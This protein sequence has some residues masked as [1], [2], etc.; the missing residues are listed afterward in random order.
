MEK[1]KNTLLNM[2]RE[3]FENYLLN[4]VV[5]SKI[6]GENSPLR[7][8]LTPV[9]LKNAYRW[10]VVYSYRTQDTT[11]I[12]DHF[13]QILGL[14]ES[15]KFRAV[16]VY[17]SDKELEYKESKKG[18]PKLLVRNAATSKSLPIVQSHDRTKN[19]IIPEDASFLHALGLSSSNGKIYSYAQKKYRQINRFLELLMPAIQSIDKSHLNVVDLGCGYG[20]LTFGLYYLLTEIYAKNNVRVLGIDLRT[21]LVDK[22]NEIAQQL[23]YHGLQFQRGNIEEFD[24]P[25]YE[26]YIALH[27]CDI[28]TDMVIR[29][30]VKNRASLVVLAP[31]CHKELRRHMKLPA[32]Y[33][34]IFI[35]GLHREKLAEMLTDRL[36]TLYLEK[37]GYSVKLMEF[38]GTEH[39]PKNT[40]ILAQYSG[41]NTDA[42]LVID[43]MIKI[44]GIEKQ[45]LLQ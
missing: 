2:L 25:N 13:D 36:R 26:I 3:Y 44:F 45:Y 43:Q 24:R 38:V 8:T 19:Y 39:T 11:Q 12:M 18:N 15:Y 28:A 1:E 7:I 27:A 23:G 33:K 4:K 32:P 35:Y 6:Q 34:D 17:S 16:H 9:T 31:C 41:Q 22:C 30:A 21:H 29:S 14:F 40:M 37:C 42:Q 10:K 20:Y 5:I